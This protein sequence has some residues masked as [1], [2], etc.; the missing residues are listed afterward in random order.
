MYLVSEGVDESWCFLFPSL[1]VSQVSFLKLILKE[2]GVEVG[3]ETA[4]IQQHPPGRVEE[5]P[6]MADRASSGC[7]ETA[8]VEAHR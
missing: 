6:A 2:R 8:R 4:C 5:A 7:R 1:P 3:V